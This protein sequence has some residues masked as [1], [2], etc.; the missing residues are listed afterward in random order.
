ML[1]MA[2]P[3]LRY[4]MAL[5]SHLLRDAVLHKPADETG[6]DGSGALPTSAQTT[7]RTNLA[8]IQTMVLNLASKIFT[9][10]YEVSY[11]LSHR[12]S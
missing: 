7:T 4:L 10:A 11:I 6:R 9:G 12:K 8:Q 2:S 3:C 1:Q 5:A